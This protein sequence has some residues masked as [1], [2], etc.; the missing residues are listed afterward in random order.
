MLSKAAPLLLSLLFAWPAHAQD[1]APSPAV[2]APAAEAQEPVVPPDLQARIEASE[3]KVS[4]IATKALESASGQQSLAAVTSFA[5][6]NKE[7]GK[8]GKQ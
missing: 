2:P 8:V 5:A 4:E 7:N 6:V 1:A 3:S